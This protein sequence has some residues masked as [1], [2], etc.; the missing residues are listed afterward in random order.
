[1][2]PFTDL[3]QQYL[4]AKESIDS[5][6]AGVL[7]SHKFIKGD[8]SKKFE[9]EFRNYVKAES[10]ALVGSGTNALLC[11]L[12]AC[13]I[14]EGDEVITTPLSFISTSE[15]ILSVGA[16]PVYVDIDKSYHLDVNKVKEKITNKT[17]AILFVDIFGQTPDIKV[18]RN[19]CDEHNLFLIED[20]A[21]AVG[22]Y[23]HGAPVG[24]ISDL[25]CFSFNPLKNLGAMGDAGA[26]TGKKELI[27]RVKIISDHGRVSGYTFSVLGLNA[28]IDD[29]Q[30]AILSAK[31]PLLNQ[32]IWKKK[33]VCEYYT[34]YLKDFVVTPI[35][36][37]FS[38]HT[39]YVYP[40]LVENRD[41]FVEYMAENGV[42]VGLQYS[43]AL[44]Q[45][46]IFEKYGK[47]LTAE[48]VCSRIV[49]LPCYPHL[50][51]DKQKY[52]IE[53]VKAWS[54]LNVVC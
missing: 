17:K 12:L 7:D 43:K 44:T 16:T 42:E 50:S 14:K 47:C 5:A 1:M 10:C 20:A 25:T 8:A 40:I 9:E 53:L 13:G 28:R 38:Y 39:Y 35:E 31:L 6:I 24:S 11:S 48:N 34:K 33:D 29:M 27:D 18:L 49:S 3:K 32:Y 36:N 30:A 22:S 37:A 46:P 45:Q 54:K 52:I 41:K 21:Q 51:I 15:V 26:V 4:D 2:I 19:L 23:C